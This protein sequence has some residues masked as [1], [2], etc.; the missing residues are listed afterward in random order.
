M[1]K[2][3]ELNKAYRAAREN[4]LRNLRS[5]ENRGYI[6][7]RDMR[8]A[9]PKKITAGSVRRI[10]KMNQGRYNHAYL[11][12]PDTGEVLGK[13]KQAKKIERSLASKRGW[14]TRKANEA[15]TTLR[16][17]AAAMQYETED[18]EPGGTVEAFFNQM[19][20]SVEEILD[21]AE[22]DDD[23]AINAAEVIERQWSEIQDALEILGRYGD[24]EGAPQYFVDRIVLVIREAQG[25]PVTQEDMRMV[26]MLGEGME[27]DYYPKE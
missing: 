10:E 20:G 1:S 23:Y 25:R 22:D 14:K 24:I 3:S 2:Q 12:D 26:G 6:F 16:Q 21:Q 19:M 7:D 4:Y 18:A 11:V 5:L 13:G 17:L 9:I 15:R 27:P 8:P